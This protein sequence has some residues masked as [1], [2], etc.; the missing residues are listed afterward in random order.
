MPEQSAL[1]EQAPPERG[2]PAD[3][4][5]VLCL[6]QVAFLVLAALG[7][8][9]LMGGNPAYLVL[10]LVKVVTLLVVATKVVK[11]RRWAMITMIVIQGVTLAGFWLAL[12]AGILPWVDD[13]VNLVGLLTNLAMPAVIVYLCAALI[14]RRR[15]Q[16]ITAQATLPGTMALPVVYYP[17]ATDREVAR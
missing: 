8:M 13:T 6:M 10:P 3:V 9:L 4:V 16:L 17:V 15:R 1:G 2:G 14:A 7:E 11:G 5:Y 12:I